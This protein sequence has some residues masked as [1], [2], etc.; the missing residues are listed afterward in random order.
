M[1]THNG[2]TIDRGR[3]V[4]S[5]NGLTRRF[6]TTCRA[7]QRPVM[8]RIWEAL[9]MGKPDRDQLFDAIYGECPEG[10]PI[11]G[12]WIFHIRLHQWKP[13]FSKINL[14]LHKEKW[15]GVMHYQLVPDVV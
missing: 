8:F 15:S 12:P 7:G 11:A 10:G 6:T 4:I 5:H 1:I 2:I 3:Q 13:E 14:R 9:I